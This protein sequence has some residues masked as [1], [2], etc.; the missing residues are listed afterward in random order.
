MRNLA[1]LECQEYK[2]KVSFPLAR[3]EYDQLSKLIKNL[4]TNI[5][6]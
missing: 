1:E 4:K 6:P 3:T 2:K 5:L